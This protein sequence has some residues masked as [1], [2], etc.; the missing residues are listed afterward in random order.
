MKPLIQI[1]CII[2]TFLNHFTKK[3]RY[4]RYTVFEDIDIDIS[5][6]VTTNNSTLGKFL[7]AYFPPICCM[8]PSS[9]SWY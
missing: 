7:N 1:E 9:I 5:S 6:E 8:L 3:I 4:I 2:E